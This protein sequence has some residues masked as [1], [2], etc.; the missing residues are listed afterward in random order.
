MSQTIEEKKKH[1]FWNDYFFNVFRV[2]PREMASLNGIRAIALFMLFYAHLYRG[3]ESFLKPEFRDMKEPINFFISNFLLNGSSCLDMFFVLS[4]F[5]ISGPLLRELQRTGTVSIKFFYIKRLLR[6]FPPYYIFL[7][8]WGGYFLPKY[9]N[10]LP[11]GH[12][13]KLFWKSWLINDALYLSN[14]LPRTVVHGWSLA[15]EEQFYLLFPFFLLGVYR[16]IPERY[17]L[18][19]LIGLALLPLLYRFYVVYALMP[20]G[21]IS[22]NTYVYYPFHGHIDSVFYGIIAAYIYDNRKHWIDW[23]ME[24]VILRRTLHLSMW[25]SIFFYSIFVNEFKPGFFSQV[26]RFN[27]FS[28]AWGVIMILTLRE[29]SLPQKILSWKGF[30]PVAKLS[31]GAY[32]LHLV[33]M[34]VYTPKIWKNAIYTTSLTYWHIL[35]WFLPLCFIT[36]FYSYIF[37]LFAERPFM[38]WKDNLVLKF[39]ETLKA[40]KEKEENIVLR[41]K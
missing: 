33:V 22:Y 17:K 9:I 36:L 26:I 40:Q 18:S 1:S 41:P 14:Y 19:S 13:T 10:S 35:A 38:L 2:D 21:N 34:Q 6:I 16:F 29:G 7:L 4:G 32:L 11:P 30:S 20:E 31:Y 25:L 12:E 8:I 15:L 24:R 5:L 3:Y 39:K 27:I 23:L 37:H 28:I